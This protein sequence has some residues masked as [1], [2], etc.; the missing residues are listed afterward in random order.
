MYHPVRWETINMHLPF[1]MT[2]WS[3]S[4]LDIQRGFHQH[5]MSTMWAAISVFERV[6]LGEICNVYY[7]PLVLT[8]FIHYRTFLCIVRNSVTI[9]YIQATIKKLHTTVVMSFRA[10]V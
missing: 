2:N 3:Q 1:A 9:A 8:S 4:F 6:W 5:I 7:R 10:L